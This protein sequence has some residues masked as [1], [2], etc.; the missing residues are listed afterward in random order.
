MTATPL[1]RSLVVILSCAMLAACGGTSTREVP[2]EAPDTM[3]T[4]DFITLDASRPRVEALAVRGGRIIAA[5]TRAE[6]EALAGAGTRT[7]GIAGV[8]V[9]GWADAHVHDADTRGQIIPG[10]PINLRGMTKPQIL[11]GIAALARTAQPGELISGEGWDEGFFDPPVFPTAEDLDAASGDHPVVL[12]R[13]DG[14]SSWVNSRV[15]RQ[16]DITRATVD[17]PGGRVARTAAGDPTGILVDRAQALIARVEADGRGGAGDAVSRARATLQ[18]YARL[19]YTSIHVAGV[20]LGTIAVYKQLLAGGLPV[21]VYVMARGD[22]TVGH[23]FAR[24]PE[25][26]LGDGQ[27]S[28]RSFKFLI[29]GALGSR[30][31][32]LTETYADAPR[33]HGLSMMTDAELDAI[34]KDARAKGFQLNVHAIGDRA[35]ARVL[36]AFERGGVTPADRFRVEHASMVASGDVARFARLGVIASMQPVFLGEYSRWAEDRLGSAR[37]RSVLPVRDLLEAGAVVACG[38]DYGASDSG[39]PITTLSALVAGRSADGAPGGAWYTPQRVD[40]DAA[41]RCM[42]TAPAYA[43]FQEND[44]GALTVGR[45]ADFTVLSADPYTVPADEL[46]HLTVRSTVMGGRVTFEAGVGS[47][48]RP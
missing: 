5:G 18:Q 39:D 38:T 31:A 21:R 16:A 8:A 28:V 12:S 44:L 27:L 33:E 36:D 37:M 30:G 23:Y 26:D 19:G 2:A 43:A 10:E 35:V 42:S 14:H 20:D 15:L 6:V 29:D 34:V 13:I 45:R 22:E 46:R 9:P 47:V 48:V 41:L 17:P 7:V 11:Q 25:P 4:G 1:L 3:F 24:G 40:V 32:L